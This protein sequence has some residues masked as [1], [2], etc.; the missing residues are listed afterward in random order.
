MA[1]NTG[2]IALFCYECAIYPCLL[3]IIGS[4]HRF[5]QD[6]NIMMKIYSEFGNIIFNSIYAGFVEEAAFRVVLFGWLKQ[7]SK[8]WAYIISSIIFSLV[9]YQWR[10]FEWNSF[11]FRV[12]AG[13]FFALIYQYRGYLKAAISHSIYDIIVGLSP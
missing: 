4:L 13:L 12:E 6:P 5:P 9:H 11:C 2:K 3:L 10:V 1:K 7:Y 8:L